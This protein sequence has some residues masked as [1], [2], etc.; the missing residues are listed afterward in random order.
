MNTNHLTVLFCLISL[1][2]FS[3]III[4]LKTKNGAKYIES[5]VDGVPIEFIFDTGATSTLLSTEAF[6]KIKNK[7]GLYELLRVESYQVADGS[8]VSANTY[9][10]D[11]IC[12]GSLC[13]ENMEFSVIQSANS[14]CLLGQNI[15]EK[16]YSYE[17]QSNQI[18]LTPRNYSG[19]DYYQKYSTET[20]IDASLITFQTFFDLTFQ[21][22]TNLEYKISKAEYSLDKYD[23]TVIYKFEVFSDITFKEVYSRSKYYDMCEKYTKDLLGKVLFDIVS[24]KDLLDLMISEIV[25]LKIDEFQFNICIPFKDKEYCFK[26]ILYTNQFTEKKTFISQSEILVY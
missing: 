16:F 1:F 12:I 24:D 20:F 15:F 21:S 26:R 23:S 3:Q 8:T 5:N 17:I 13:F 10:A 14:P 9:L 7:S 22:L 11:S 2:G 4:P 6:E 19:D 25:A 18:K